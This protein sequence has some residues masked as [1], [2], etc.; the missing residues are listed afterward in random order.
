MQPHLWSFFWPLLIAGTLSAAGVLPYSLGINPGATED[1]RARQAEKGRRMPPIPVL[2]LASILQAG[3]IIAIAIY[4]G[5][6]ASREVGLRLPV[7]EAALAGQPVLAVLLPILPAALL[8]GF[9]AGALITGL[10]HFVFQPRLPEAFRTIGARVAVWKRALACF[11]GGI[12][13]ELLLRL[14]VMAGLIWLIGRVFPAPP[15]QVVLGAFWAANILASLLFGLGHLPATARIAKLT[16]FIITRALVL[17]GLAG[18]VFGV[19]YL[20]YGLESAMIAHFCMDI[21][22]H[23]VLPEITRRRDS[24]VTGAPGNGNVG[25]ADADSMDVAG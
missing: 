10:E 23:L 24:D 16:P 13:E 8:A 6:L 14:F 1:I 9:G 18:L 22:M 4:F 15:G 12:Y 5:L 25:G 11:Y 19:L 20:G 7:L 21:L 3:L 17:N 2:A